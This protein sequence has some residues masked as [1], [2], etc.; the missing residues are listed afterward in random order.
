MAFFARPAWN[1]VPDVAFTPLFRLLDDI[2]SHSREAQCNGARR[3]HRRQAR[4]FNPKFDVR[5]TDT[6]YELHGELPGVERDNIHIEFAE[7]QTVV[8]RGRVERSYTAGTPPAAA[9]QDA[10]AETSGAVADRD[11]ESVTADKES[12]AEATPSHQATVSDEETETTKEQGSAAEPAEK[13]VEEKPE[14]PK[15]PADKYWLSERSVGEFTRS[16]NF[17]SRV[18]Q[19]AVTANLNNGI[20]T[21]VV[22]KAKQHEPRYINVN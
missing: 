4:V 17:S 5:E 15:Q 7:P 1:G 22:P 9:V 21:V 6:A 10:D 8:I 16:F 13:P 12:E 14:E 19:E 20:L 3:H 11:W 2:E 18:E